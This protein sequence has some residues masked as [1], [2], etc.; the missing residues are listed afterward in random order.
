LRRHA[1]DRTTRPDPAPDQLSPSSERHFI[2]LEVAAS[3]RARNV[4]VD[5]VAPKTSRC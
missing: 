3:L 4:A 5:V 2:G 1:R